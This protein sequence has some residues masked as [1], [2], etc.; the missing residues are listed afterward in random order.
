MTSL[1]R[2]HAPI[3]LLLLTA[4]GAGR[5]SSQP[6][7]RGHGAEAHDMELV[8]H[9]DLQGRAAY[10]PT[11]HAQRGRVLA[12]VGH[13]GGRT[14][15]PLTGIDEDNGT[16]IVDVTDPARPHYLVHIPGLPGGPEQGGA[17]MA[18]V[19]G[20]Q[21]KTYLLRTLGNGLAGA[22]H[23]V[24]DVTD[25]SRPRRASTIVSG[26]TSTHKN[27]W[28]CDTG[29]AYLIS[30]DL[31]KANPLQVGPSRLAYQPHDQDLRPRRSHPARL[32]S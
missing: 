18:R 23:E 6:A 1:L 21:G 12:Y 9:D 17:P 7:T 14:R 5:A 29:T 15:N 32:R 4:L 28:E 26:L 24:W 13:H 11:I 20:R 25:P 31:A 16:S 27:F 8:G 2:R 30:G 19:C 10:Q 22:G 3:V